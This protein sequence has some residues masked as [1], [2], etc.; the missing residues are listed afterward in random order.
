M[1]V[2]DFG[3]LITTADPIMIFIAV[4]AG[5]VAFFVFRLMFRTLSVIFHLGCLVIVALGVLYFLRTV[6]R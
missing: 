5:V 6:I 1:Q 4:I 2:P 3:Q